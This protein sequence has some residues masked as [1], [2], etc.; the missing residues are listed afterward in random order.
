MLQ[1]LNIIG[2]LTVMAFLFFFGMH[3]MKE[4]DTYM[5]TRKRKEEEGPYILREDK[6]D[7]MYGTEG[8]KDEAVI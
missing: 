7:R 3:L 8:K 2:L 1:M 5:S 6:K 4:L